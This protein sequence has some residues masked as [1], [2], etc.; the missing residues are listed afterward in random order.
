MEYLV[1]NQQFQLEIMNKEEY[2]RKIEAL[3]DAISITQKEKHRLKQQFIEE[4]CPYK[5][6]DK[7]RI[8]TKNYQSDFTEELGYVERIQA[9]EDG[10]F[11]QYC[12]ACKR[13]AD[14]IH[15]IRCMFHLTPQ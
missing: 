11:I 13:T 6:G 14:V 5:I 3:N 2:F 4:C 8:V 7:V 12:A 15:V 9:S 1:S 10:K